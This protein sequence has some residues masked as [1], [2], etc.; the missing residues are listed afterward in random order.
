V[1]DHAGDVV[2][3]REDIVQPSIEPATPRTEAVSGA[4]ELNGN[5][6][7]IAWAGIIRLGIGKP[8]AFDRSCK[9]RKPKGR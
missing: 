3:N 9:P 2:L 1:R 4:D 6:D 5:P 7:H 8:A